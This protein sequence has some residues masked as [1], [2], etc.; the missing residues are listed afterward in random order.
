MTT[1]ERCGIGI[2]GLSLGFA[3]L[4]PALAE[5]TLLVPSQFPTITAAMDSA[6][7]WDTILVAP[8][9]YVERVVVK[10]GV[11]LASERGA[12][13]TTIAYDPAGTTETEAVITLQKC[14]NSTQ[15]VGFTI[16][17]GGAA[18]RGV[19]AIGDGDPV[20]AECRIIGGS[21][22]VGCHRNASPHLV[23]TTIEG[24][25]VA[26][27][28][29]QSGSADIRGCEIVRGEKVGLVIEGTTR[30]VQVRD[31]KIDGNAEVG[32]RASDG[33][34][35]MTGG[36]VSHNGN[37]GMLLQY[38]SPVIQG[39]VMEGNANI[40]AV[41]ENS[42]DTQLACTVRKNAFGVLIAGTGE[43]KVFRCIFEDNP[44][45]H[46]AAEGE[47]VPVI[48]GSIENANLF[49]GTTAAVIQTGCL[50]SFNATYN[51]WGKPCATRDQVKRISGARDVVRRPWVTA[52]LK[53]AFD[54]CEK[55]R[56]HSSTPVRSRG[57]AAEADTSAA[58]PQAAAEA[59]SQTASTATP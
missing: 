56:A 8:G 43:P 35:G 30:P 49:L 37:T 42:T 6:A 38:V 29:I 40:G 3:P 13:E 27:V 54:S 33:E 1:L 45:A 2:L 7:P 9:M 48:G 55:A 51:Y 22:G 25:Q 39:T 12:A 57:A 50:N 28:F 44:T 18:K 47:V 11:L 14:S 26:G 15:V 41:L 10:D 24:S 52:D 21:N 34:F 19:L 58:P 4:T 32:V 16:D 17:G 31:T 59:P 5:R 20:V 53:H 23:R 36:S 46:I